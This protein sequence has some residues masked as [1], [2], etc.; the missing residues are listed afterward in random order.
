MAIRTVFTMAQ[1]CAAG[2]RLGWQEFVRDYLGITRQLLQHYFPVLQPELDQH[3]LGMFQRPRSNDNAW[4]K[5]IKF[6]NEREFLMAYRDLVF[7]Y[8]RTVAR[9]PTPELSLDQFREIVK[10]LTV[11]EREVMWLFLKGYTAQQISPMMMNAEATSNAVKAVADQR[12]KD[13][14]PSMTADAYNIS[15][16]TLI[17]A[18]EKVG[19]PDCLP[20]KTFNNIINGQVS[21]RERDVAE[22]HIRDCFYCIDRFTSFQEMI[23]LKKDAK[24]APETE[25][26]PVL[27]KL[28]IATAKKKGLFAKIFGK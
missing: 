7:A 6:Q 9:V 10:D 15:A 22:Q 19:T 2:E 11:V 3:T 4:F 16:R 14:F 23:R 12:L 27:E 21:W 5:E 25:V 28:G 8:A 17:E 26:E 24:P 18:A 20:L 13:L 1:D